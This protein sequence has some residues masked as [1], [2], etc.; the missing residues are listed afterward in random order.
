MSNNDNYLETN[1]SRV[2]KLRMQALALHVKGAGLAFAFCTVT[3]LIIL[4]FMWIGQMLPDR[5]R[6]TEDP[7]PFSYVLPVEEIGQA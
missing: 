3:L 5:S 1:G 2:S 7:T 6:E 4:L